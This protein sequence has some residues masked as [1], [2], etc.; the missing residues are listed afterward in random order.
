MIIKS[1]TNE[2]IENL[3]ARIGLSG[4]V[5][6][7]EKGHLMES[8]QSHKRL[9][10]DSAATTI[11]EAESERIA[12]EEEQERIMRELAEQQKDEEEQIEEDSDDSQADC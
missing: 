1:N 8:L 4:D 9:F 7:I 3:K 5:Y 11:E 12:Y 10:P 2:R 6:F